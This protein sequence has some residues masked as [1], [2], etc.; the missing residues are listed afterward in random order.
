MQLLL[1]V[2]RLSPIDWNECDTHI[3]LVLDVVVVVSDPTVS[4]IQLGC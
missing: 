1:A 3:L 2:C 4:A